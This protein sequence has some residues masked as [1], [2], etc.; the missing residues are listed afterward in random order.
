MTQVNKFMFIN[1]AYVLY[2]K[3]YVRITVMHVI[4]QKLHTVAFAKL[5]LVT[6]ILT[7]SQQIWSNIKYL[8][9]ETWFYP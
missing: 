8:K 5:W 4:F 9:L 1:L 3:E 7:Y 6:V 2:H